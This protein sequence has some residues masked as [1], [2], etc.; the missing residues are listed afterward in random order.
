MAIARR[1]PFNGDDNAYIRFLEIRVFE[2]ENALRVPPD[3]NRCYGMPPQPS[4]LPQTDKSPQ[5]TQLSCT[6]RP[7]I[8]HRPSRPLCQREG[9]NQI[10]TEAESF[11]VIEFHPI[12]TLNRPR[13]R[14]CRRGPKLRW[15]TEMDNFLSKIP[16]LSK[17][18]HHQPSLKDK[19]PEFVQGRTFSV[20]LSGD[21]S[22]VSLSE[23][24]VLP[25][26]AKFCDFAVSTNPNGGF[27]RKVACFREL[28]F[29]SFCN[30][31][32]KMGHDEAD[33]HKIMRNYSGSKADEKHLR[34]LIAGAKWANRA[35]FALSKTCWGSKSWEVF[36]AG[37]LAHLIL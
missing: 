7:I 22:Q 21:P 12:D 4:A 29:V 14:I 15:Q 17:W 10:N 18:A 26:L 35:I 34:K 20:K 16:L 1:I 25:N 5:V 24:S 30:V 36:F 37:T 23:V 9:S 32:L 6:D 33:V 19:V 31:V 8:T 3:N 27:Y 28:V 2:L 11:Q 13:K